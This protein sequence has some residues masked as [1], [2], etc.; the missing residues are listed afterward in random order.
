MIR[1][2]WRINT[3]DDLFEPGDIVPDLPA[4][5]EEELVDKRQA[6]WVAP[7][8]RKKPRAESG[9]QRAKA[10]AA[11]ESG[12]PKAE[13]PEVK[14]P[15]GAD[16]NGVT[17]M[18]QYVKRGDQELLVK[19]SEI[20]DGD[21]IIALGEEL[22]GK[23]LDAYGAA[24]GV[25]TTKKS[26]KADKLE[27]IKDR[28]FDVLVEIGKAAAGEAGVERIEKMTAEELDTY[29]SELG[30][31]GDF[32]DIEE[33]DDKRAQIY[34]ELGCSARAEKMKAPALAGVDESLK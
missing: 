23:Q 19:D 15:D 7:E 10:P 12:K 6:E 34:Y 27:L 9:G 16:G 2:I 28:E 33:L 25:D 13:S 4:E 21:G 30:F 1:A 8:A 26:A 11:R 20:E 18:V 31:D 3:G 32:S 24:L 17:E 14:Q 22:T 5:I 29:G